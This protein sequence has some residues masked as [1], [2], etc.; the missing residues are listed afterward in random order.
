MTIDLADRDRHRDAVSRG[1]GLRPA[2]LL[3][4]AG[5][6]VIAA[7]WALLSPGCVLSR[8][9]T[10]DLLFNLAGAWH[11]ASGHTAHVDF[12]EP[13]GELTFLLTAL[14][15]RIVGPTPLALVIGSLVWTMLVFVVSTLVAARRLP[16]TPAAILPA[17]SPA[18][19]LADT[20]HVFIPK[21]PTFSPWTDR[22]VRLY[23]E[24]LADHFAHRLESRSW[25]VLSRPLD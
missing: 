8:E 23:G 15:F 11:I 16:L 3:L 13:V 21:F 19:L 4:A 17:L 6:P 5:P 20:D 12:H 22:A 10:W 24:H 2:P 18:V 14:G 1:V 9:M 25:I 7:A